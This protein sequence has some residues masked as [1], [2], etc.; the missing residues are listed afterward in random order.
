[1]TLMP[2]L[3]A[4]AERAAVGVL[5]L[6]P[7]PVLRLLSG[8][9]TPVQVDGQTLDAEMQ[10]ILAILRLMGHRSLDTLSVAE[11]RAEIRA[12]AKLANALGE[13]VARIEPLQIPGPGGRIPARLY[14]PPVERRARPLVVYYHG[15]GWTVGDLDTHDGVCRFLAREIDACVLAIDYRLAPEHKFPAAVDDAVAA[16]RWAVAEAAVFDCD[17]TRVAVAGDSAGGNLSAVVSLV[18]TR[19]GGP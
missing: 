3:T 6:V 7:D 12:N 9:P 15:G 11:A 16:F 17:P 13:P 19:A 8:R 10:L 2:D 5:G 18:T 14:V 4:L 1:M